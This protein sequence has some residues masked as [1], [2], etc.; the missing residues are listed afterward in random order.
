MTQEPPSQKPQTSA[1]PVS[2]VSLRDRRT[3]VV[4]LLSHA[5]ARDDLDLD[6][7][8]RRMEQAH[9]ALTLAELDALVADVGG[10][11]PTAALARRETKD[12]VVRSLTAPTSAMQVGGMVDRP[13]RQTLWAVMGGVQRAGRWMVPR[14]T[15]L[16]CLMG[17][18]SLDFREADLAPGVTELTIMCLMGGVEVI[19]PPNL[20]V[21]VA[22]SAILGGFDQE[23]PGADALTAEP[24]ATLRITGVAFAGGVGVETRR[25]GESSRQARKR[26]K[27]ER[28][29]LLD[30]PR[31]SSGQAALP[32][33]VA[34]PERKSKR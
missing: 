22:G 32:S 5:F 10:G 2:L 6:E 29:L 3:Q 21:E 24:V 12:V 16:H 23:H 33:A 8:D 20:H 7:L 31:P 4:A 13:D 26:I 17:G 18:I 15:T 25:I 14:H 30:A 34:L 19:V 11:E 27:T 1:S 9:R 28:K